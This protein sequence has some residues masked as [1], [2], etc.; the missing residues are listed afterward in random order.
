MM[1]NF[2]MR[3]GNEDEMVRQSNILHLPVQGLRNF[4]QYFIMT[5]ADSNQG[6]MVWLPERK[7]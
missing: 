7:R 6:K 3:Y 5:M 4:D 1:R 2:G